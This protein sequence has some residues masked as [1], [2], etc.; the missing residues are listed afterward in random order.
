MSY[1][2]SLAGVGWVSIVPGGTYPDPVHCAEVE[3]IDWNETTETSNLEDEDGDVIDTFVTKRVIEGTISLKSFSNSLIALTSRGVTVTTGSKI[4][5]SQTSTIPATPFEITVTNGATFAD[6]LGVIDLTTS[7]PMTAAATATGTGVYAVNTTTGV[8]TFN[9]ADAAHSVL[10]SYRST[11]AS[12]GTTAT[13]AAAASASTTKFGLHCYRNRNGTPS[14]F[15]VPQAVLHGL[16]AKFAKGG[17]S[18]S[19]IKFTATKDAS[20][21]LAYLYGPE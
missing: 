16:S 2:K 13:I 18:D 17:W 19:T 6:D 11:A 14:G 21:N 15:Y 4:G 7:K 20:G 5:Y 9:T 10:I 3:S 12:T 8:Y 1:H